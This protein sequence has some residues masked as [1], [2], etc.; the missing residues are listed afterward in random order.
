M[1]RVAVDAMVRAF[2]PLQ[3]RRAGQSMA[4][5]L[6][7]LTESA[8]PFDRTQYRPG[9]V[10]ASG[11]VLTDDRTRLLLVYHR[12]LSRWLQPGGHIEPE[13]ATLPAAAAREVLEETGVRVE[14]AA[15]VLVGVDVHPIPPSAKRGEPAHEHFDCVFRFT[16][17]AAAAGL[18]PPDAERAVWCEVN[19][20]GAY[21]PDA[22][23]EAALARALTV[24]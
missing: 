23:L 22:A 7:L 6:A 1:D 17:T 16:A 12:R 3:D 4:R 20:L 14:P 5:L 9:H 11:L 10:T 21:E 2:G 24:Q 13:D 15:A 8:A 18:Q 19:R